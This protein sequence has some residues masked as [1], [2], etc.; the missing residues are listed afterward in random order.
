[1]AIVGDAEGDAESRAVTAFADVIDLVRY[2]NACGFIRIQSNALISPSVTD[3]RK[4]VK[5]GTACAGAPAEHFLLV[6]VLPL[7]ARVRLF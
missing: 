1:M 7:A 5:P 3:W 2:L 4:P 6:V